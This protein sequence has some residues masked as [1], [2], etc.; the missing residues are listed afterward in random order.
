MHFSSLVMVTL[1]AFAAGISA[2]PQKLYTIITSKQY[3]LN[4][5]LNS[6]RGIIGFEKDSPFR[7]WVDYPVSQGAHNWHCF[8]AKQKYTFNVVWWIRFQDYVS[9]KSATAP[10]NYAYPPITIR[11]R[12]RGR[13]LLFHCYRVSGPSGETGLHNRAGQ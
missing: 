8:R 2:T 4:L 13:Y 7:Y 5:T 9:G 11:G 3:G 12:N 10:L 1:C 6:D